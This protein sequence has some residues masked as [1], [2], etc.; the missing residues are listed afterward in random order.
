[1]GY[2]EG[3]KKKKYFEFELESKDKGIINRMVIKLKEVNKM[4]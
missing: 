4:V 2:Q 1:M 3:K